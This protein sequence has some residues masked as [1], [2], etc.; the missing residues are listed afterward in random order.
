MHNE[1][2][3]QSAKHDSS[4]RANL[5]SGSNVSDRSF[6]PRKHDVVRTST[7]RGTQNDGREQ[8]AKHDSLIRAR[9]LSDSNSNNPILAPWKH[10]FPSD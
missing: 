10:D 2:N 6:K 7:E 1:G 8:L 9:W 3:V 4:I 5:D